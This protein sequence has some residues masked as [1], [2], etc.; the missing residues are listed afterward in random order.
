MLGGK[1]SDIASK[2]SYISRRPFSRMR[3]LT[4]Q[5]VSFFD[6]RGLYMHIHVQA[7]LHRG[8][9]DDAGRDGVHLL[10]QALLVFAWWRQLDGHGNGYSCSS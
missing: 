8:L 3:W 7:I 4:G 9:R 5:F 1:A 2:L 6:V 10:A